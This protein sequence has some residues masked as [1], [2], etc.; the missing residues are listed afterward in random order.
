MSRGGGDV[1]VNSTTN[2]TLFLTTHLQVETVT[3]M[4]TAQ[5]EALGDTTTNGFTEMAFSIEKH[6][7]TVDCNSSPQGRIHYGTWIQEQQFMV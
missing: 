4:T 5:G 7:V 3:G 1:T 2:P 6:T